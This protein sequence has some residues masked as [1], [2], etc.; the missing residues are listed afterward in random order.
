MIILAADIGG[1]HCR[2][3]L[4]RA[5]PENEKQPL[6]RLLHERWLSSPAFPSFPDALQSLRKKG[7]DGSPPL[8][9]GEYDT[10]AIAALAPAGPVHGEEC[11]LSNVNWI[12][13]ASDI[14]RETDI[15]RVG[16]INDFAAQAYACL[17]P[18]SQDTVA[19]L[20]GQ[21]VPDAPVAVMGAGTGLGSALLLPGCRESAPPEKEEAR[22]DM[23]RRF[24]RARVLPC[25][26]GH[27]LF[28]FV[29]ETE[30]RF[31]A[32][33]AQREG[34]ERLIGDHIVTGK[35]LA[36]I[37]AFHTGQDLSPPEATAQ[38]AGHAAVMEDFARYY[39]RAARN[40]VLSSLAL[41]GLHITGGMATRLPVLTHPAFAE[42]LRV[43]G[44]QRP[45]MEA[46]PVWHMRRLHSGLWGAALYGLLGATTKASL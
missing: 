14:R 22:K 26:G 34:T 23:L 10:P 19:V 9:G 37:F 35:G 12:V 40:F 32:F 36:H 44:A 24:S 13:R 29:G 17:M 39:A 28:P 4:F 2:F 25:E 8:I 3:A 42:E 1:T 38:A 41:G 5:E 21:A 46:L 7:D 11:R 31:A 27:A 6:L 20:E 30:R 45:L 33:A 15:R 18:Q 16:L 43:S